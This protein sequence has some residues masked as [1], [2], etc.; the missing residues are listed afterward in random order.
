MFR[1][2]IPILLLF[3]FSCT[4]FHQRAIEE[5][6]IV[7][8]IPIGVIID[9]VLDDSWIEA[10]LFAIQEWNLAAEVEIF[11]IFSEED[12]KYSNFVGITF[13]ENTKNDLIYAKTY[14]VENAPYIIIVIN[15]DL[16]FIRQEIKNQIMIHELGHS[17]GFFHEEDQKS[18]MYFEIS[19]RVYSNMRILDHHKKILRKLYRK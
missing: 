1:K 18:I 15:T 16:S 10:T 3:L 13:I 2:I 9:P 14:F 19:Y 8:K 17:L 11:V 6:Y 5:Q 4:P 7:K 12:S